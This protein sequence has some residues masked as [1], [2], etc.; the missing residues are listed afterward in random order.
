MQQA[1]KSMLH[2]NLLVPPGD[3]LAFLHIPKTAGTSLTRA[4]AA[5]WGRVKIIGDNRILTEMAPDGLK[6]ISLFAGHF[7]AY[8]LSHP[9]LEGFTPVTVLR[10]P[11]ARLFS[12]YKW[13]KT[14]VKNGDILTPQLEY[15]LKVNFFEYAFSLM[16]SG[17]HSQLIILGRREPPFQWQT[18]PLNGLLNNAKEN[19]FKMRIGITENLSPFVTKLFAE[20]GLPAP[21][22]SHLNTQE[23]AESDGLTFSQRQ[24]LR[25]VLAPDYA[26][27][28]YGRDLM[29][30][31]LDS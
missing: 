2:P 12:E 31:W 16:G 22:V 1:P 17:R 28:D 30:R 4:L 9:A 21:E 3:R 29:E 5:H 15:A 20:V 8:Q 23:Q 10:D 24:T 7:Y 14:V 13:A 27:Y 18:V 11:L 19:L 26:L 25:E 6:D